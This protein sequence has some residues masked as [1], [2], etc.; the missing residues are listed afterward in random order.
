MAS[1]VGMAAV[2]AIH[3][4]ASAWQRSREGLRRPA[5]GRG[6]AAAAAA[7]V[8]ALALSLLS[9]LTRLP[10][11]GGADVHTT[12]PVLEGLPRPQ[13]AVV[14]R[15]RSGLA[16]TESITYEFKTSHLEAVAPF[17]R[18]SLPPAG[19]AEAGNRPGLQLVFTR[20]DFIVTVVSEGTDP[21]AEPSGDGRFSVTVDHIARA[22]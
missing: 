7:V 2:A 22:S 19:W 3:L 4:A 16:Q 9:V 5:L 11:P 10:L 17:Y 8:C 6:L 13:D 18:Q 20:G 21:A 1:L 14:L 12:R 15:E